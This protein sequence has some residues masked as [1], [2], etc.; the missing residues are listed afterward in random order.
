MHLMEEE[1]SLNAVSIANLFPQWES[2]SSNFDQHNPLLV[3]AR[4]LYER[5]SML[6]KTLFSPFETDVRVIDIDVDAT[7][8][9]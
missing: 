1:R 4:R 3:Q 6:S 2:Y 9:I 7:G 5:T 8:T